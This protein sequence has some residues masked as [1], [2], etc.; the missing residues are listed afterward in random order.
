MCGSW[1]RAAANILTMR[2]SMG[3]PPRGEKQ[4]RCGTPARVIVATAG[5]SL[6]LSRAPGLLA[7]Q[8]RQFRV[9]RAQTPLT[10]HVLPPAHHEGTP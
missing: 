9:D 4:D 1:L 3:G 10:G 7:L 2:T 6:W 5:V 8:L